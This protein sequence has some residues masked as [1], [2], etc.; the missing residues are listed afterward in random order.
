MAAQVLK[1]QEFDKKVFDEKIKMIEISDI[2]SLNFIFDD[3]TQIK[4]TWEYKS[5]SE[6]WSE[7]NRQQA[8]EKTLERMKSKCKQ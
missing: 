6:S 1:I 7:E 2:R 3:G 5:R 8:R 4:K